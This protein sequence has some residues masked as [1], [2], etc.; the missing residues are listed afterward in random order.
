MDRLS[1]KKYNP[2][3]HGCF[4][5][6][7]LRFLWILL[8]VLIFLLLQEHTKLYSAKHCPTS[9]SR[10]DFFPSTWQDLQ[11]SD[12]LHRLIGLRAAWEHLH[13][14]YSMSEKK[15]TTQE[16]MAV[17]KFGYG[18]RYSSSTDTLTDSPVWA[19][20]RRVGFDTERFGKH[21]LREINYSDRVNTAAPQ[22]PKVLSAVMK[23]TNQRL[24][25]RGTD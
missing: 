25:A 17:D 12:L 6:V 20:D 21:L 1:N 14:L 2:W 10:D 15:K 7:C 22:I 5:S 13:Y 24:W 16:Q 8:L 23:I 18:G 9:D 4:P 3:L 19:F 11:D